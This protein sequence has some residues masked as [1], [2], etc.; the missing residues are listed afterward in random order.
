MLFNIRNLLIM[1]IL[2]RKCIFVLFV[3]F[4]TH[5]RT[6]PYPKTKENNISTKDKI[7]LQQIP[8]CLLHTIPTNSLQ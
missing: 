5:Y 1:A 2:H 6:L 3:L 7:E 8:C 4:Q